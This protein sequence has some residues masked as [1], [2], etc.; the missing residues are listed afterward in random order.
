M[1]KIIIELCAEDRARLDNILAAL[2]KSPLERAGAAISEMGK[3]AKAMAGKVNAPT[4]ET[5]APA[6]ELPFEPEPEKQAEPEPEPEE[7]VPEVT[8]AELQSKVVKLV[9]AGKKDEARAIITEYAAN[10]SAIPAEKR[11]EVLAR[12]NKLEG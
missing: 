2:Q 6:E 8:A 5:P 1:N 7:T 12:L 3:A 4:Q 10:V 11:A 9:H